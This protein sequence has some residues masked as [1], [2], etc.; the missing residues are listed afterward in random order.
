MGKIKEW[1]EEQGLTAADFPKFMIVHE[2]LGIGFA[3]FMWQ[4]CYATQPSMRLGKQF[5]RALPLKGRQGVQAVMSKADKMVKKADVI[6]RRIPIVKR[7]ESTRLAIHAAEY[8]V[9]PK[10]LVAGLTERTRSG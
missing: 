5:S 9:Q 6:L 7:Y 1:F 3:V 2:T 10:A 8:T 4:V